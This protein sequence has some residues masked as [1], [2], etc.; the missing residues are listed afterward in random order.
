MKKGYPEVGELVVATVKTV[1]PYGA[2]V[3]LDEYENKEGFIHYS[4]TIPKRQHVAISLYDLQGKYIHTVFSGILS[5]G[6]HGRTSSFQFSSGVYI[7]AVQIGG[8]V[9]NS[10]ITIK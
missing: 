3:T 2:F 10:R 9:Y 1:K 6:S 5:S 7:A 4:V 8:K